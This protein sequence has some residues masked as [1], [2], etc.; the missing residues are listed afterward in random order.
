M[1]S[2]QSKR[3]SAQRE[4]K[5]RFRALRKADLN[6]F[7]PDQGF[8]LARGSRMAGELLGEEGW[9]RRRWCG[10]TSK[11]VHGTGH[12]DSDQGRSI[13]QVIGHFVGDKTGSPFNP[14][15]ATH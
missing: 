13:P 10:P 15:R 9:V 11:D 14:A 4:R 3:A 5:V 12:R 6:G 1:K 8:K 7:S 2:L